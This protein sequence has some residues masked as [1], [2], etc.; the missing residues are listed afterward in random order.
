MSN[1]EE[2]IIQNLLFNEPYTRKVLP[3][4]D[5]NYFA[6]PNQK[7]IIQQISDFFTEYNQLPTVDILNIE[8]RNR[9]DINDVQLKECT[10]LIKNY[11]ADDSKFEWLINKTEEFCKN[12]AVY[13][14]ILKSIGIIDNSDGKLTQ[15]AIPK[16]LQDALSVSFDHNIG[17]DYFTDAAKRFDFY[18]KKEDRIPFDL[19]LFNRITDGGMS[20][21]SLII[22]LAMTGLGKTLVMCHI[23]AS[24]LAQSKN[25]LYITLEMAEEKIAQRIDANLFNVNINDFKH[26]PKVDFETRISKIQ[27]KTNGKLI[28][29]EYPTSSAHAGHFRILLEELKSKKKFIP[30]AVVIDYLGICASARLKMNSGANSYALVKSIAEEL[31][32]LAME[33]NV[34]IISGA[35]TNR[36]LTLDTKVEHKEKGLINISDLRVGDKILGDKEFVEV[37]HVF[38][39]EEQTVYEIALKS[40]KKIKCS[41][42]H[43]FPTV[44]GLKSIENLLNVGDVLFSIEEL[45][46][47]I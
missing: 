35:Q 38:P 40:G 1:I 7:I 44:D 46:H 8:L 20:K 22:F 25:V 5:F 24:L 3:F 9:K 31:R 43:I 16:I 29:K 33:Y 18:H 36:C 2:K 26:L 37:R 45:G 10:K 34:P 23:A 32:G 30:D 6:D 42:K 13:N 47:T 12:R 41:R 21:K 19:S 17:H 28:I 14:A 39:I 4:I 11:K 15:E 27:N